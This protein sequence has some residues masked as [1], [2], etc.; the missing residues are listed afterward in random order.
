MT[1]L[2]AVLPAELPPDE[3]LLV[4][5]SGGRDSVA[6]LHWL[7][8]LG[9]R[10]LIV[11]HLD[12][13]LRVESPAEAEFVVSLASRLDCECRTERVD[14][15]ALAK[16]TKRSIETAARS[17][18]QAFFA[19][20]AEAVGTPWVMLGHHADDQVE[21]FLF[22]LL[23]GAGAGGL[24]GMSAIS[25]LTVDGVK[26]G[27]VRPLLAVWRAEIDEY[28]AGHGL[29]FC[30]DASNADLQHTRN[31]IRH[32]ALPALSDALGR[33]VRH[34]LW[35]A[36]E[37]LRAEDEF[38]A[39]DPALQTSST[40]LGTKTLAALPLALQRRCIL[41]WLQRGGVGDAGFAEVEAVRGLLA[42]R[43]AKVNLPAN[44]CARRRAGR[45]FLDEQ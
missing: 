15:A 45:I 17:A 3:P 34:A 16:R 25:E 12:H 28:I 8:G 29:I 35:R 41:A 14:V 37:L 11:C 30:E 7:R 2:N 36:S 9:E 32:A 44:R 19:R 26:L 23:R 24:G 27:V 38:I 39:A 40:E 43:L 1:L 5:V 22:N 33:D 6:L 42:G 18:R 13:G 10:R 21:T 20:C 4:G 31:R